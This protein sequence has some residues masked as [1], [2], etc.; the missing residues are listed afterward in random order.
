MIQID[1]EMPTDCNICPCCQSNVH[2]TH[3]TCGITE[4]DVVDG[5]TGEIFKDRPSWC[6]LK[7][8]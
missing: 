1:M 7:E 5:E 8:V 2:F 3:F 4:D 6:P